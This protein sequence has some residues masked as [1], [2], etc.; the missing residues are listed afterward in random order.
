MCN[1]AAQ[2]QEASLG[3]RLTP[4]QARAI[5]QKQ[6][7]DQQWEGLISKVVDEVFGTAAEAEEGTMSPL[8]LNSINRTR[9][10]C[11]RTMRSDKRIDQIAAQQTDLAGQEKDLA[12]QQLAIEAKVDEIMEQQKATM[13][14]LDALMTLVSTPR[15]EKVTLGW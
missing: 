12:G 9:W 7:P 6:W 1:F 13:E 14:K 5:R 2:S 3:A 11:E 15:T 10:L 4:P 8:H